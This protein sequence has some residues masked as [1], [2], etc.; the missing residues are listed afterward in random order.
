MAYTT[1]KTYGVEEAVAGDLNTYQRDNLAYLHDAPCCIVYHN[2]TQTVTNGTTAALAFNSET[3]DT[4]SMHSTV[5][6]NSRVTIPSGEGGLY[7]LN[8]VFECDT[9][10]SGNEQMLLVSFRVNG[11]DFLSRQSCVT[12]QAS[13][14]NWH[15]CAMSHVAELAAGDYV[16]AMVE[17]AGAG[18]TTVAFYA[19]Y[20]PYF[21]VIR[22]RDAP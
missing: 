5:T 10:T 17:N 9:S 21:S 15:G 18:T 4:N 1:P 14:F 8:I 11:S 19:R 13:G 7:L 2:T 6:N 16:E 12:R 22:I 3:K 20:S